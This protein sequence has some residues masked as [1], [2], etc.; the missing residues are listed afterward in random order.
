MGALPHEAPL[1]IWSMGITEVSGLPHPRRVQ[2]VV[3]GLI[4]SDDIWLSERDLVFVDSETTIPKLRL[5]S[6]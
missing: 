2:T 5:S 6:G 4:P 1:A 3:E